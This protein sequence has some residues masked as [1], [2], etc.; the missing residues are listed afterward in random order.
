MGPLQSDRP[1]VNAKQQSSIF[2]GVLTVFEVGKLYAESLAKRAPQGSLDSV[3]F[4]GKLATTAPYFLLLGGIFVVL[5]VSFRYTSLLNEGDLYRV[6]LG[7]LNGHASGLGLDD[8]NQYGMRFS[9]GYV[10][11][12]YGLGEAH[13]LDISNRD[14]LIQA[15]NLI[16]LLA[17]VATAGFL[18]ASLR[19]MYDAPTALLAGTLFILSPIFLE[20]ATS[21]HQ[22]L[23]ALAFFFA[24]NYLL[25]LDVPARWT[26]VSFTGA[27][28]LLFLGLTM[29]AELPLAFSW[30]AF[31]QRPRATI[32]QR[33]Y[34][35]GFL[36]RSMVCVFAF[37]LF[38]IVYHYG[39]YNPVVAQGSL[40]G[41]VPFLTQFYNFGYVTRGCIVLLVGCGLASV[42]IGAA[43]LLIERN[44]IARQ[45]RWPA[46]ILSYPNW[47]GPI[48]LIVIGTLFWLPNPYPA[49]HFTFVLLGAT[50]LIALWVVRRFHLNNPAAIGVGLA[51]FV[52]NQALAEV[53]RPLV[54]RNLHSVYLRFPEHSPTTGVVPLGSFVRHHANMSERFGV[55]TDYGRIVADS[56]E[57]RIL[58]LTSNG[59]QIAGLMFT[60]R[61]GTLVSTQNMGTFE[62]LKARRNNQTFLFVDP[63][64]IWPRDPVSIILNDPELNEFKIMRDPY[65]MSIADK[66]TV[67]A[68]RLAN[69]PSS[70]E[71]SRCDGEPKE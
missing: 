42:G 46:L 7:L 35:V 19:I 4:G 32:N 54:L 11:M 71:A 10:A 30:L 56:C 27:T 48:S 36:S 51:V 61:N 16:G 25:I 45:F 39:V 53:V 64:E 57:P 6:L 55:L 1:S 69:D 37:A 33:Q 13:L 29:R 49:R 44:E 38:Q 34:F 24:A 8:P 15:I 31:A 23:I 66:S 20:M 52:A 14:S 62:A 18:L 28:L 58:V 60:S 9:Y 22:L 12:I 47:L 17:S 59:A 21:G 67:P 40:N 65:S 50:V 5:I 63:Q 70:G 3:G 26:L 68:S 41:I 43:S 2:E